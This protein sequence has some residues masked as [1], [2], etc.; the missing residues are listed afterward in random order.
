MPP[1]GFEAEIPA[2]EQPQTHALN[3]AAPGI[4]YITLQQTKYF[5]FFILLTV[6]L[7]ITSGR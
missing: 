4:V 3:R 2:I 7:D 1:P 6:R 5:S